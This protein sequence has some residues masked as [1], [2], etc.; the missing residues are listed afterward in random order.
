MVMPQILGNYTN[1]LFKVQQGSAGVSSST[2][3]QFNGDGMW[4]NRMESELDDPSGGSSAMFV[5]PILGKYYSKVL[6]Q[7]Q[8][9]QRCNL[10]NR[11]C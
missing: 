4:N 3:M 9:L 8:V 10:M 7:C 1:L 2:E 6:Q 5:Q 11:E